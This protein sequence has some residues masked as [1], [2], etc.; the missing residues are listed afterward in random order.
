MTKDSEISKQFQKLRLVSK[1][2]DKSAQPFVFQTMTLSPRLVN[3]PQLPDLGGD[4]IIPMLQAHTQKFRISS[5][6]DWSNAV[7][8]L[9]SCERFRDLL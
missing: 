4:Q 8:L 5:E 3:W 2:F 6:L 9:S 7:K 1:D